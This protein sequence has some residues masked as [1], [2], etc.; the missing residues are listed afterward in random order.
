[1][2]SPRKPWDCSE[3]HSTLNWS[4]LK[5]KLEC[6]GVFCKSAL[7]HTFKRSM[8]I[9]RM[10]STRRTGWFPGRG[11]EEGELI[12][13]AFLRCYHHF[14]RD[15]S[16]R[17][18]LTWSGGQRRPL[19]LPGWCRSFLVSCCSGFSIKTGLSL[20]LLSQFNYLWIS[21]HCPWRYHW[22][23]LFCCSLYF[24]IWSL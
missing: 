9:G 17:I 5:S 4:K 24:L 14:N 8:G 16:H 11:T 23:N 21:A 6:S 15:T 1:M 20:A 3:S 10:W 22:E 7:L 12:G 18:V 2:R 13:V 19:P